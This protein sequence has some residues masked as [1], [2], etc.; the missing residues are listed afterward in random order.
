MFH[1]A[2]VGEAWGP[3]PQCPWAAG[4]VL[5]VYLG[6]AE[7]GLLP[8]RGLVLDA[9]GTR[10]VESLTLLPNPVHPEKKASGK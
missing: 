6:R 9:G 4:L 7:G 8:A 5:P 3:S 2:K 1:S 10:F